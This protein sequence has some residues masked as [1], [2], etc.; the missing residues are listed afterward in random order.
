MEIDDLL[1][2]PYSPTCKGVAPNVAIPIQ[3]GSP[4]P[5]QSDFLSQVMVSH[6][7]LI[8]SNE[9]ETQ[10]NFQ[11]PIILPPLRITNQETK[12]N[13]YPLLEFPNLSIFGADQVSLH[14][15]TQIHM[16]P[17][18]S[19]EIENLK[20]PK[21]PKPR[22]ERNL[23]FPVIEKPDNT[24]NLDIN[25]Y[26]HTTPRTCGN[27]NI[28]TNEFNCEENPNSYFLTNKMQFEY[29]K[30][31]N[32]CDHDNSTS[33]SC[34]NKTSD[35]TLTVNDFLNSL[36]NNPP[37]NPNFIPFMNSD[38]IYQN[39]PIS[40]IYSNHQNNLENQYLSDNSQ[41]PQQPQQIPQQQQKK[42]HKQQ[43]QQKQDEEIEYESEMT[44]H[45]TNEYDTMNNEYQESNK[46]RKRKERISLTEKQ[47]LFRDKFYHL[48]TYRK[49]F[50]KKVVFRIHDEIAPAIN[51][52]KAKRDEY[53]CV[54]KYF[55]NFEPFSNVIIDYL[56]NISEKDRARIFIKYNGIR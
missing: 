38:R 37:F 56:K 27:N 33:T 1:G 26:D 7:P 30:N 11:Q 23:S 44:N 29:I 51:L 2:K 13:K 21:I 46:F 6:E 20:P 32:I 41:I 49:K 47:K 52:R 45:K 55:Q 54:D 5:Q 31:E 10:P 9:P 16:P 25:L 53:R 36:P 24:Q 22:F 48:F 40:N 42:T 14:N 18:N 39:S 50:P 34:L 12:S 35:S 3:N 28:Q 4:K 17:M 43:R 8:S 15:L 19:V